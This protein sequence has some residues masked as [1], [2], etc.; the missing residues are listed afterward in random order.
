MIEPKLKE[1]TLLESGYKAFIAS[2]LTFGE[3]NKIN[4]AMYAHVRGEFDAN[5]VTTPVFD[6]NA[7]VLS[8][9][10]RLLTIIKKILN[11]NGEDMGV[12]MQVLNDLPFEDGQLLDEECNLVIA[13][14]K[15]K[16]SDKATK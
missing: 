1:V 9:E 8:N 7:I 5:G 2:R 6:G 11:Q 14:I 13:E 16:L 10:T 15:K 12:T 3:Y 4:N